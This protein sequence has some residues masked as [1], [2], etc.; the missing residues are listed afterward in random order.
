[1]KFKSPKF[2][3]AIALCLCLISG[4]GVSMIQT[5]GGTVK[6]T[7]IKWYT[8]YGYAIDAYLLVPETATT[9][10]PAPGI[11][12]CHGLLNN[13]EMQ[14]LNYVELAR[15]GYV[16][17]AIDM[18][19]HGDSDI[20]PAS[21]LK[22]A[23]VYEGAL[24]MSSLDF[25]D[26]TRIGV[27]GH[28]AGGANSNL[29]VTM[30]NENETPII[31]AAFIN[32]TD[33]TYKDGDGN[34]ANIYGSRDV[35]VLAG[36]YDEFGFSTKY[37]DGS[38]RPVREYI[39]SEEAQSFLYF[40]VSDA[41]N[42]AR[43]ANTIYTETV[44][45]EEAI[46][47]IYNP[48]ITH[49][50]AHFSKRATA[51]V[52]EFF[53]NAFGAPNPIAAN[54]QVWQWKVVFNAIGLVGF[55]MFVINAAIAFLDTKFFADLKAPED[56]KPV[57][58]T[59]KASK[60]WFYASLV[61]AGIFGA[62][63][64]L[65]IL[66][67]AQSFPGGPG[68]LGQKGVFGV[69][70][71][72]LACGGFSIVCMIIGII[73]NGKNSKPD[74]AAL[75]LKMPVVKVLKSIL[76][77]VTVAASAYAIVFIDDYF[78]HADFRIWVLATKAFEPII[79][80]IAIPFMIILCGFYVVN[81]IAINCFNFNSIGGKGNLAIVALMNG[82]SVVIIILVQYLPF[83]NTGFLT[84][85]VGAGGPLH[86]FL[87]WTFPLVAILPVSAVI[88]RKIYIKTGNPYLPGIINAI[89][90]ALIS[91]ANTISYLA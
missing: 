84:Y 31:A 17:L 11:V 61:L 59:K 2:W 51:A 68:N 29:A 38:S 52:I 73:I 90:V 26:K 25:V 58:V 43:S 60:I 13:K 79:L 55:V 44:D 24:Y 5:S 67:K 27:Q 18:L 42:P 32:S 50:W 37:A 72:A 80:K 81:S 35:G 1:M 66:Q 7:E 88:A 41:S 14:D 48:A 76:L 33:P 19:S 9:D 53:E 23:S 71:W 62:M 6:M 8:T 4:I 47:V 15:R 30:D 78:F 40:G 46:R 16:V 87:V 69:S 39:D 45:G 21:S 85:T 74:L 12:C 89:I 57:I 49:P 56:M 70:M 3:I 20:V 64:Y 34:Y 22:N 10:N 65:P 63:V 91:C 28:S 54:D 77:A 75:G 82:L 36:Q 86:L 83:F